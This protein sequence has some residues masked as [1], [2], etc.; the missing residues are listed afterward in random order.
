M[1]DEEKADEK[2]ADEKKALKIKNM[3]KQQ[4]IEDRK[5]RGIYLNSIL[6]ILQQYKGAERIPYATLEQYAKQIEHGC[7]NL[8]IEQARSRHITPIN[9]NNMRFCDIYSS[10]MYKIKQNLDPNSEVNSTYLIDGILSGKINP[11]NVGYM[12]SEE[13]CPEKSEQ[14]VNERKTRLN[15]RIEVKTTKEY[16]CHNCGQRKCQFKRVQLRSLDEGYQKS[17]TCMNCGNHWVES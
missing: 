9:W 11:K 8:S 7:N 2:K 10:N 16:K 4:I 3:H 1:A 12:K 14:I 5:I 13:L 15:N 6:S 17:I